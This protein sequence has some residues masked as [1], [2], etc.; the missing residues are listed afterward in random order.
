MEAH[1][2]IAP[3]RCQV[4]DD[5]LERIRARVAGFPWHEMPDD[6]GWAYGANLDYMK[7]L[8]AYWVDGFDWRAAEARLNAFPQ[9]K[10][11][12]DGIP[13]FPPGEYASSERGFRFAV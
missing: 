10:A 3:F 11:R 6:G 1:S 5:E 13:D 7:E 8:C 12:V 2:P 9:F 4:S